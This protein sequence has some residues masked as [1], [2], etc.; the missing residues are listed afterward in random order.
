MPEWLLPAAAIVAAA[1]AVLV[2]LWF[3]V[4]KPTIH[5]TATAVVQQATK[6]LTDSAKKA[7]NAA[8]AA[9]NA[10]KSASTAATKANNA[11][12]RNNSSTNGSGSQTG[13][14]AANTS[15]GSA[16]A[17]GTSVSAL[18]QA[19]AKV[20]HPAAFVT[21]LYKVQTKHI[22]AITDIVLENPLG[23]T[24]VLEIRAGTVPLFDFG[25][26]N[27]RSIDY[28]FIQ[29][30]IFTPGKPLVLAVECVTPAVG[31]KCTDGLSFSGALIKP[32]PAK[33]KKHRS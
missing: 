25:L 9:S 13:T 20:K 29:P 31:T 19:S 5:D 14:T 2:A 22:L 28:H 33:S 21:V 7:D 15:P 1:A 32:T 24:G 10:A 6:K 3:T 18:L 16:I 17:G 27:F 8:S 12:N 11:A 30:L 23:D 26:A 4:L